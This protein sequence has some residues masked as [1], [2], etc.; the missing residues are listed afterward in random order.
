MQPIVWVER[1]VGQ[2]YEP[3]PGLVC[4]DPHLTVPDQTMT[5]REIF[6]RHVN[7]RPIM[8]DVRE[9]RYLTP[10]EQEFEDFRHADLSEKEAM[11]KDRRERLDALQLQYESAAKEAAAKRKSDAEAKR[12]ADADAPAAPPDADSKK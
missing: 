11:L 4:N 9:P 2:A 3:Y 8:G 12:K 10:D 1:G 5:P 6:E 7:G